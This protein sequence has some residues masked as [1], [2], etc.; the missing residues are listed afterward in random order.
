MAPMAV[1]Q[2]RWIYTGCCLIA[3]WASS[4]H[5]LSVADETDN[6]CVSLPQKGCWAMER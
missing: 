2:T 6:L 1:D 5:G 4:E 3:G